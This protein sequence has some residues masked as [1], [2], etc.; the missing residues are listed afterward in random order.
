MFPQEIK[1]RIQ[2]WMDS[3]NMWLQRSAILFQLKYKERTDVDLLLKLISETSDSKEFFIEINE[4]TPLKVFTRSV[5]LNLLD[6]AEKEGATKLYACLRR[7]TQNL[8]P[9]Y[10]FF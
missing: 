2:K 1:L 4:K 9:F 7:G 8:G 6:L 5:L 10:L 3:G